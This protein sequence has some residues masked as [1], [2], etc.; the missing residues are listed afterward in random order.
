MLIGWHQI[1][2]QVTVHST[3]I[4]MSVCDLGPLARRDA[5]YKPIWDLDTGSVCVFLYSARRTRGFGRVLLVCLSVCTQVWS[6]NYRT[7]F[8][9]EDDLSSGMSRRVVAV[10]GLLIGLLF[11]FLLLLRGG[12]SHGVPSTATISDILG[13][14]AWVPIIPYSSTGAI[15]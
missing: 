10:R 3:G 6:W 2:K 12:I 8:G 11:M 7:A 1:I 5:R 15:W 4:A 9:Y 13:V 14:P